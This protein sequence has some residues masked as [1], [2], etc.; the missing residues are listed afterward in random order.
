LPT[1]TTPFPLIVINDEKGEYIVLSVGTYTSRGA[2]VISLV[3][4]NQVVEDFCYTPTLKFWK[5]FIIYADCYAPEESH[6]GIAAVDLKTEE[7]QTIFEASLLKRYY[8]EEIKD[9]TLTVKEVESQ[10]TRI[11]TY[12]LEELYLYE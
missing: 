7:V 11:L 9:S 12:N 1:Q 10:K 5:N 4:K 6:S 2:V 8:I 3:T